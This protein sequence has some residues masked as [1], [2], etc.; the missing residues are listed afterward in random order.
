MAPLDHLDALRGVLADLETIIARP[1]CQLPTAP[2]MLVRGEAGIGKTHGLLDAAKW[3]EAHGL[4][5]IVVF[6][7]DIKGRPDPW[8]DIISKLGLGSTTGSDSILDSLNACGEA[9]GL[10]LIIFVDALNE[11][12]PDRSAWQ[13]WLPPM[14]ERIKRRPFLKICVSCRDTYLRDVMPDGLTIPTVHHNGFA[15]H[16]YEAQFAFFRHF[17]LGA[18]AEPLLHEEFSNPLFLRLFCEAVSENHERI[19]PAGRDGLRFVINSLIRAKNERAARACDFDARENRVRGALRALANEMATTGPFVPLER[20]RQLINQWPNPQSKSLL[21]ILEAESLIS[22]I[23]QPAHDAHDDPAYVVRF[24]FERFG[25]FMI[26]EHVLDGASDLDSFVD[27]GL[28]IL[29]RLTSTSSGSGLLEAF[30]ILIPEKYEVELMDIAPSFDQSA[31]WESFLRTIQWRAP[32]S[33][34]PRTVELMGLALDRDV[35]DGIAF[36]AVLGLACRPDHPLNCDFLHRRLARMPLLKRDPLL[37]SLIE[38]SYSKWTTSVDTKSAV[39]RLIDSAHRCDLAGLPDDVAIL[40]ST[41]LSWFC[42]SPDRRVRDLSTKAMVNIFRSRPSAITHLFRR[43]L[44]SDDE[45][46]SERVLVASYGGLLLNPSKPDLG[47]A[48]A[49]AYETYFAE[50]TPPQN[51]SLRDHARLIIELA[52][53]LGVDSPQMDPNRY[54]PPYRS[55][56]PIRFPSEESLSPY[57][58]DDEHFPEMNLVEMLGMATGTDF[59]R[60]VVEPRIFQTFDMGRAK[61]NKL[62]V[63]RWFL[64]TAVELGYPGPSGK[65]ALFDHA[66]IQSYGGG[67]GKPGWAERLGK[68]YYWIFLRQLVGVLS[69]HIARKEWDETFPPAD[70]LQG[71]DLRDIDP[72]DL[73]QFSQTE[74]ADS[75]WLT[76]LP[77]NFPEPREVSGDALWAKNDDLPPLSDTLILTGPDGTKWHVLDMSYSWRGTRPDKRVESYR[78]VQRH[79]NAVTCAKKD[80]PRVKKAFESD[81]LDLSSFGPKD[82]RGYLAEYPHRFSY[83]QRRFDPISFGT[84]RNRV[85]FGFV[86]INQLRGGEWERDYSGILSHLVMPSPDIIKVGNLVWDGCG[87][88]MDNQRTIQALSPQWRSDE[89]SG[90]LL[91]LDYLDQFLAQRDEVLVILGFQ[92]KFVAGSDNGRNQMEERTMLTRSEGRTTAVGRSLRIF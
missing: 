68:K 31:L 13:N 85:R 11:T 78:L 40:W 53:D 74:T 69:D 33:I 84:V 51:A 90:L 3:R 63:F 92:M 62:D 18:P 35:G 44:D 17:K 19:I 9:T 67:R 28:P 2:S 52:R 37:A 1:D 46:I 91:R 73:R 59:A 14:I 72:T 26:A 10:P 27:K 45:Y 49:V 8:P 88:W 6:G 41:I 4:L 22:V 80:V 64:K 81:Q 89:S 34:S 82:Y 12:T 87:G 56:W 83:R 23:R 32:T 55:T 54:R 16:E 50:G 77:Y 65:C 7:E 5:S 38:R 79:I 86:Q 48:A 60:Y 70:D 30:S 29:S 15:G 57:V 36:D 39:H 75:A 21:T 24:T 66:V 71:L 58:D 20:A 47:A 61:I 42:A 76:P 25:D 43:F